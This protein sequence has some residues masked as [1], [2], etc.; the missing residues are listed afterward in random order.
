MAASEADATAVADLLNNA[1][2]ESDKA[3]RVLA[4]QQIEELLLKKSPELLDNFFEE[5]LNF[6]LDS[7][8]DVRKQLVDFVE[9]AALI[10]AGLIPR[11]VDSLTYLYNDTNSGVVKR[12]LQAAACLV[13]HCLQ[14]ACDH[15][16]G[17]GRVT[18]DT[19][20]STMRIVDAGLQQRAAANE[21]VKAACMKLME[22][23]VLLFSN[24]TQDTQKKS[25]DDPSLDLVSGAHHYLDPQVLQEK[26]RTLF[27][28]LVALGQSHDIKNTSMT[29]VIST[30]VSIMRQRPQFMHQGIPFLQELA[31]QPPK[32]FKESTVK[33]LNRTLKTQLLIILKHDASLAFHEQLIPLLKGLGAQSHEYRKFD[34]RAEAREQ[35]LQ[36]TAVPVAQDPASE[37][38]TATGEPPAK[39][40]KHTSPYLEE[41]YLIKHLRP[42]Q[43]AEL[44]L[45]S[46]ALADMPQQMPAWLEDDG[47]ATTGIS[48]RAQ[49]VAGRGGDAEA[50]MSSLHAAP[51][52]PDVKPS[53][54][55]TPQPSTRTKSRRSRLDRFKVKAEPINAG[56][57]RTLI[58]QCFERLLAAEPQMKTS[59]S[60]QAY[61]HALCAMVIADYYN[62]TEEVLGQLK[63]NVDASDSPSIKTEAMDTATDEPEAVSATPRKPLRLSPFQELFLEHVAEEPLAR[64]DLSI[65]LMYRLWANSAS[66]S[67]EDAE[68]HLA[69]YDFL[70][71]KILVSI[72]PGL[73]VKD[74][75]L[76][77]LFL[78]TPCLS[79]TVVEILGS[80][81]KDVNRTEVAMVGLRQLLQLRPGARPALFALLRELVSSEH[82]AVQ[83]AAIQACQKLIK[84]EFAQETLVQIAG[85]L[86]NAGLKAVEEQ[87][88]ETDSSLAIMTSHGR[89]LLALLPHHPKLLRVLVS[90]WE[91]AASP[92]KKV[93]MNLLEE[94]LQTIGSGHEELLREVQ[95]I[96][97]EGH[98]T[99][100][101]LCLRF[102]CHFGV[103]LSAIEIAVKLALPRLEELLPVLLTLPPAALRDAILRMTQAGP[104]HRESRLL[105][106]RGLVSKSSRISFSPIV[107]VAVDICLSNGEDGY[108]SMTGIYT[109]EVL[110]TALQRICNMS[111]IPLLL[112]HTASRTLRNYPNLTDFIVDNV[113]AKLLHKQ[114]WKTNGMWAPL[115]NLIHTCQPKSFELLRLLPLAQLDR[116]LKE[117]PELRG[118]F[119]VFARAMPTAVANAYPRKH[120]QWLSLQLKN[121]DAAGAT[122][123]ADSNA[124][125]SQP[126][127]DPME[128]LTAP[129]PDL[130]LDS[131]EDFEAPPESGRDSRL[132]LEGDA[133]APNESPKETEQDDDDDDDGDAPYMPS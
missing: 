126:E 44:I 20:E 11:M 41:S 4:L 103:G 101:L 77:K 72:I 21:G 127:T 66:S 45:Q 47:Q 82:E 57:A 34:R 108:H 14:E 117:L 122:A 99:I 6:Q 80:C 24:R 116:L 63:A 119:F 111:P 120:K 56:R 115:K 129:P 125:E 73:E 13:K 22:T 10:D 60:R 86:F 50:Q 91:D 53:E 26:G 35:G 133:A 92:V 78:E 8:P 130:D 29:V 62:A 104:T 55:P 132:L 18:Q 114:V 42:E 81:C 68:D 31:K 90:A 84:L 67:V 23:C 94:P 36:A 89:L 76:I 105:P 28:T 100:A 7:A 64:M 19:W 87:A 128:D 109:M 83:I 110:V 70:A 85:D 121:A 74:H 95:V 40:A 97:E 58:T 123:G 107:Q 5:I 43:L 65:T 98:K 46:L 30:L 71:A 59:E 118:A 48:A 16:R 51:A 38:G 27:S 106:V 12:A 88:T 54:V 1:Q 79:P 15:S 102:M 49:R 2:L 112:F 113:L 124:P 75:N 69:Q 131:D 93:M 17:G 96:A 32:H 33:S 9:R 25:Q 39:L 52:L 3:E 37:T 61:H